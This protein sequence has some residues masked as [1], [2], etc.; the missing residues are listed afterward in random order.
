MN[1]K[2]A[3]R[4]NI[5]L[6]SRR[7]MSMKDALAR[8]ARPLVTV[9]LT[10][11]AM[12]VAS[13]ADVVSADALVIVNSD[14]TR[15]LDFRNNIQPYLDNFGVPYS[16]LDL[17][18]NTVT[19][20]ITQ[21]ALIIIGHREID[22]NHNRIDTSAQNIL[23][24]SVSN[25]TGLVNF[26]CALSSNGVSPNYTFVQDIFGFTY[27]SDTVSSETITFPAT[28]P[29]S[30]LHY[31]TTLHSTADSI[32]IRSNLVL[33]GVT[34]PTNVTAPALRGAD[35]L[36]M[37]TAHGQG[38]AV[39]W[40]GYDW[41]TMAV[42]GPVAGLDDLVWR[43]LV[44]AARK[45]FVMRGMPNHVVMRVDDVA[46][47][48]AETSSSAALTNW[49]RVATETGF[50]P[51]L[52]LF[53]NCLDPGEIRGIRSA[54]TNGQA[55]ASIHSQGCGGGSFFYFDHAGKQGWPDDV[56]AQN[57][58]IGTQ[59][60]QDNGI[61]HAKTMCPHYSEV[62]TNI[63]AGLKALGVEF[64]SIEIVPG[65]VEYTTPGAP[66]LVAG[67]YRLYETPLEGQSIYPFFYADFLPIPN[68]PELDGQFFNC[69]TEIRDDSPCAEWCPNNN[70]AN[71]VAMGVR[72]LKRGFDSMAM[73]TL[74]THDYYFYPTDDQDSMAG[75][76]PITVN[77]W[78]SILQG[79]TNGIANYNPQYVTIDYACQYVRATRT[80]QL[81][82]ATYNTTTR[83]IQLGL[84]GHSDLQLQVQ[85]FVGEGG[86]AISNYSVFVA[87]FTN[88]I[89]IGSSSNQPPPVIVPDTTKPTLAITSPIAKQ[90]WSNEVFSVMGTS[91]DNVSVT[92]V[93]CQLNG[94]G[95]VPTQ[96][97]NGWTNW[98]ADML[99]S[100]GSNFLQAFATDSSGNNSTTNSVSFVCVLTAPL[101]VLTNGSGTVS[102]SLNGQ[103]L[104]IGKTYTLTAKPAVRNLFAGWSGSVSSFN[105]VLNFLMQSNLTL[106]AN[107]ITNPFVGLKGKFYGLFSETN[108]VRNHDRSGN[109][110]L[111]LAEAG[112]YSA[113][114][115]LGSK[116]LPAKGAFDWLG[117][118]VLKLKPSLTETV[119][120]AL[121][122][123]VTNL[124]AWITGTVSNGAWTSP[125]LGYRA[126]VY[127]AGSASPLAGKY[128][129]VIPGSDDAAASPGG[130]GYG[131]VTASKSG[132]LKLAGKLADGTT[133][134]QSIPASEDGWWPLY[135]SLYSSK[136]SLHGW[137]MFT[138]KDESDIS[139]ELSWIKSTL[140]TSRYY[141][142]GFTNEHEAV[143]SL[144]IS[145]TTNRV[146]GITNGTVEFLHG[147]LIQPIT[148]SVLLTTNNKITNLSSNKLTMTFT[149]T[150]GLFKGSVTD[151]NTGK[152]IPFTGVLLQ[153]LDSGYGC[154]LGTNQGGQMRFAP[155]P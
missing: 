39:Q 86:N 21:H 36:L 147:N 38:R 81:T 51:H 112:T 129:L 7:L 128:T 5:V 43:S 138:N 94:S 153:K 150:S 54:V 26:D 58:E 9:L 152:A 35:P 149:L 31:V 13:R 155:V 122:L 88:N 74:Y 42:K 104:E 148:N 151:T 89:S 135:S 73:A 84:G 47:P 109:F 80:A 97:L 75:T 11:L 123:D 145:P 66:W 34:F 33:A 67:P 65:Q 57:F 30:Q 14:S 133:L 71:S 139:G 144:Y 53:F 91:K 1:L 63:F 101:T 4:Q 28:E 56:M 77:N 143:G 37:V 17:K 70:V 41:M 60:L 134:S 83:E 22:P 113:S 16:V 107:F 2:I 114:L 103:L 118:S 115:Q 96:T 154:F 98:T 116:K 3:I 137:M 45:P 62:G 119:T 8:F 126:P 146:V 130:D 95:W 19:T 32:S 76:G 142:L 50:K 99:L 79:I 102:P 141:P 125:L 48:K 64:T 131:T 121:Q 10:I 40:G 44:W 25:G 23:S 20:D 117:Q 55:T 78:R 12:P 132:L 90:R 110:T 108:D 27:S 72:Q 100:P 92:N 136:G 49:V 61:P 87:A 127:P 120:V 93:A 18:T 111:T 15:Y 29:G 46:G 140:A 106:Q 82:N 69:Y 124:N 24:L 6:L 59:W 105:P 52:E 68:H 85:V